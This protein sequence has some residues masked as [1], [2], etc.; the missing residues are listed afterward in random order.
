MLNYTENFCFLDSDL[1][2]WGCILYGS[3]SYMPSNT[4]IVAILCL[5]TG[6]DPVNIDKSW[7][8]EL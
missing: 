6:S 2:K 7:D 3:A 1:L 8:G 5:G 4:V